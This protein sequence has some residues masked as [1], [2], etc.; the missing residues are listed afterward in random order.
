MQKVKHNK[1]CCIENRVILALAFCHRIQSRYRQFTRRSFSAVAVACLS[2]STAERVRVITDGVIYNNY[3]FVTRTWLRYVRVYAVA[4][5]PVCLS[6][7][8]WNVP[9]P[10]S[11]GWNF[12]QCF[13]PFCTLDIG[14]YLR[15]KDHIASYTVGESRYIITYTE[16]QSKKKQIK[17]WK[18][19]IHIKTDQITR[20]LWTATIYF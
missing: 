12:P 5:P 4:N 11:A 10:Y 3:V 9:A 13:T 15:Q 8:V 1:L 2:S 16:T 14:W 6:S 17:K 7:V 18:K 19:D 20:L